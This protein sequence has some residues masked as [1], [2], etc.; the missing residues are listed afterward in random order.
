MRVNLMGLKS[1][2]CHFYLQHI[3]AK[4]V[5]GCL[6]QQIFSQEKPANLISWKGF[7]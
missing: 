2:S 7:S 1:L 5:W 3:Q 4:Q 6:R